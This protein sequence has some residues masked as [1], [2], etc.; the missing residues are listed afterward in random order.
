[1]KEPA[2]KQSSYTSWE[3]K[4]AVPNL[5]LLLVLTH[6]LTGHLPKLRENKKFWPQFIQTMAYGC[7][8]I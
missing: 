5:H 4:P 7:A 6:K 8:I 1:M 3:I 2:Y